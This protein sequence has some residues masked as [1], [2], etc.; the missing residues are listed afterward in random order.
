MRSCRRGAQFDSAVRGVLIH[1]TRKHKKDPIKFEW[2]LEFEYAKELIFQNCH[3]CN[4]P[5]SN[6]YDR[7]FV[8]KNRRSTGTITFNYSGLDR[9]DN[10]KGY[11]V[12]NTV[13]CCKSCNLAKGPDLSYE[14]FLSWRQSIKENLPSVLER[15][16]SFEYPKD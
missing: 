6:T 5:P 14:E 1:Y 15:L 8:G 10:N 16:K 7:R 2:A 13:P 4:S 3:Y 12:D 11:T 9:K